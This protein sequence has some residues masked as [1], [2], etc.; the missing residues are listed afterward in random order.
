MDVILELFDLAILDRVYANALPLSA[1]IP[2]N[3][4]N[5]TSFLAS[6]NNGY[7]YRPASAFLQLEPSNYAYA[8]QW[9]RDN[10]YRQTISLYFITT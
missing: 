6:P 7:V 4:A 5:A 8:S 10:L 1:D 3:A 9:P 2:G